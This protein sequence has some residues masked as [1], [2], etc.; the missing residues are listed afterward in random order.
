MATNASNLKKWVNCF[1][2]SEMEALSAEVKYYRKKWTLCKIMISTVTL[3]ARFIHTIIRLAS[4]NFPSRI[5]FQCDSRKYSY[6]CQNKKF[7]MRSEILVSSL[8]TLLHF[9]CAI[10]STHF[11]NCSLLSTRWDH[12]DFLL[13]RKSTCTF[14]GKYNEAIALLWWDSCIFGSLHSNWTYLSFSKHFP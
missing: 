3:P 7:R 14:Y 6:S 5:F 8:H 9:L 11:I 2:K 10:N 4:M 1:S 13:C 12:V